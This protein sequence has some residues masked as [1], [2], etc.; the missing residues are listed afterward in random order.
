VR[1]RSLLW[2][3]RDLAPL[4]EKHALT[5]SGLRLLAWAALAEREATP[6]P[7]HYR[8]IV[9]I[10]ARATA[11]KRLLPRTVMRLPVIVDQYL[12]ATGEPVPRRAR[13]FALLLSASPLIRSYLL[14]EA[15][16]CMSVDDVVALERPTEAIPAPP[17]GESAISP[18]TKYPANAAMEAGSGTE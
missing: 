11:T 14:L 17:A 4:A 1:K 3:D 7:E 5:P 6:L 15:K 2:L 18:D 12:A 13:I 9:P 8:D 16:R 10:V